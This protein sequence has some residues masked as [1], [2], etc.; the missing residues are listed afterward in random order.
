M[1]S[2]QFL[3]HSPKGDV[4]VVVVED[5]KQGTDMLGVVA[6]T[7]ASVRARSNR[8]IPIGHKVAL[9]DFKRG[10]TLIKC[11]A[12][13]GRIVADASMGDHIHSLKTK[14]W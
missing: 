6:E 10:D 4:G 12:D 5:L 2:P 11:G 1:A 7:D 14:R 8:D 13:I 9:M 3:V